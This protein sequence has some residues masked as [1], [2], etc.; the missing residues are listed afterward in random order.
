MLSAPGEE[1]EGIRLNVPPLPSP[2]TS[3]GTLVRLVLGTTALGQSLARFTRSIH[4][5][6]VSSSNRRGGGTAARAQSA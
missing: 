6:R 5:I 3:F 2:M 1:S 4:A